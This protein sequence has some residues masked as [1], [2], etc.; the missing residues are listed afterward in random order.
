MDKKDDKEEHIRRWQHQMRP[1][2]IWM[3]VGLTAFF[4]L[5]T[6]VQLWRLNESNKETTPLPER[7]ILRPFTCE[8]GRSSDECLAQRRFDTAAL[9]EADT[10]A[11]RYHQANVILFSSIWSR[12][13][14]FVTGMALA[15]V[16]AAFILGRMETETTEA[17]GEVG[18]WKLSLKT[19]SPGLVLCTFGTVLM[20]VSIAILHEFSSQDQSVY[21]DAGL[22]KVDLR[23]PKAASAAASSALRR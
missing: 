4:F 3:L 15:M 10:V 8:P 13:L 20:V 17:G 19:A 16:G 21:V 9:L 23:L 7:E 2:M 12:Y 11:R 1:L 6:A 22:P 18:G 5:A 14:G